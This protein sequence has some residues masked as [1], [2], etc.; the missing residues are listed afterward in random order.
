MKIVKNR[1]KV[2]DILWDVHDYGINLSTREVYIHPNFNDLEEEQGINVKVACNFIKNLHILEHLSKEHILIHLQSV[3]G[4]W[5]DGMAM[6]N[7]IQFAKSPISI[8]AYAQA[9]SMT[10]ILFQAAPKRIMMPDCHLMIHHGSIA[11]NTNSEAAKEIIE[12][13]EKACIRMVDIF[14]KRAV[15]GLFFRK[16]K[17]KYD[18]IFNYID[19][20]VKKKNDWY[21]D[22]QEAV[23]YGFADGILGTKGFE[24]FEALRE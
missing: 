13:N 16:K 22:A 11:I 2:M 23:D 14:A 24:T 19:G 12:F 6:F 9:S 8:V 10:G 21:L 20:I 1:S 5:E 3:G 17:M 18:E 7:S 15:K 4:G